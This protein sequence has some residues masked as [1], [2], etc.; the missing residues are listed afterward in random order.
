MVT[1]GGGGR[2]GRDI[3]PI[4]CKRKCY[5]DG[6]LYWMLLGKEKER[7]KRPPFAP[8]LTKMFANQ[9]F[10]NYIK[11]NIIDEHATPGFR[12]GSTASRTDMY[13]T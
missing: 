7:K 9:V 5:A 1:K 6:F 4:F 12:H 2:G 3:R 10:K 11:A 8:K 13:P